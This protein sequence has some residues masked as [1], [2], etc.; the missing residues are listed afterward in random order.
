MTRGRK[1]LIEPSSSLNVH[2]PEGLRTRMDLLLFSEAEGRVPK[3]A[4]ARFISSRLV[5]FFEHRRLDLSPYLATLP[6]EAVVGG[7]PTV[8]EAL[9]AKLESPKP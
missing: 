9:R 6:G 3:G 1:P 8:L 5:E 7:P 2:L 4:Y